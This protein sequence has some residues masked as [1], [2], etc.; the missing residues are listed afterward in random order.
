MIARYLALSGHKD[1]EH[2]VLY[3][4]SVSSGVVTTITPP[5]STHKP[6]PQPPAHPPNSG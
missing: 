2:T 3:Q 1:E 4:R 5:I 6:D